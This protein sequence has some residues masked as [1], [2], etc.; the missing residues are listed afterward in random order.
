MG[1][2]GETLRGVLCCLGAYMSLA[3]ET[4][5]DIPADFASRPTRVL[6]MS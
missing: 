1:R 4:Y 6:L 5:I 3:I 2:F